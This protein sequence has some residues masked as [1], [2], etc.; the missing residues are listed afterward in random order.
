MP[1]LDDIAVR[2]PSLVKARPHLLQRTL[3]ET[4]RHR[5]GDRHMAGAG[6]LGKQLSSSQFG[7]R[8]YR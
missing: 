5:K 1:S 4:V 6:A 8:V 3:S 7:T 2:R